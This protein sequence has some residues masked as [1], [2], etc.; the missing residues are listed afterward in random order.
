MADRLPRTGLRDVPAD[1]EASEEEGAP[2]LPPSGPP[3]KVPL[4][5][6]DRSVRGVST[7]ERGGPW[8]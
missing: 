4:P 6:R 5:C 2:R 7:N 1:D 8:G 3:G